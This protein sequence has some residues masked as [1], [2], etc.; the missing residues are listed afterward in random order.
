MTAAAFEKPVAHYTLAAAADLSAKQYFMC[1]L[2]STPAV[3]LCSV[4]GE[5]VDGILQ[6]EPASGE[7]A[8]L[9]T[10]G[11]SK[12]LCGG[13][14]AAGDSVM[15]DAAGEAVLAT[16]GKWALGTMLQAGVDGDVKALLIRPHIVAAWELSFALDLATITDDDIIGPFVPGFAGRIE[17]MYFVPDIVVTTAAKLTTLNAEIGTTNLTGGALDLTSA[18]C[19]TKGVRVDAAAIT[20]ANAFD[21]DDAITIEASSTTTFIEGSGTLVITGSHRAA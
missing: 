11:I 9:M 3:A 7:H 8:E 14:V 18:N 6:N 16:I 12:V 13:T 20:A 5:R 1:K 15:T 17:N 10:Y 21:A 2:N 19:A 4:A